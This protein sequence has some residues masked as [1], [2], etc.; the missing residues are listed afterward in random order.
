MDLT[1]CYKILERGIKMAEDFASGKTPRIAMF[2]KYPLDPWEESDRAINFSI[3]T[4]AMGHNYARKWLY[5]GYNPRGVSASK[6]GHF[7]ESWGRN[8]RLG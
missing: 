7:R 3:L 5:N 4:M 2:L 6:I 8:Y 1:I